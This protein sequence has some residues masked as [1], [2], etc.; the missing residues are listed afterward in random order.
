MKKL[1]KKF[2]NIFG[3]EIQKYN[4]NSGFSNQIMTIIRKAD[5]NIVFDVGAN[6]GQFSLEILK[7]GF[8]G[9]II[10][11]EPLSKAR[12]ELLKNSISFPQWTI[13]DRVALGGNNIFTTNINISKNSVSSSI[14]PMLDDHINAEPESRY[15]DTEKTPVISLDSISQK[16]I[17]ED[18]NCFLKLDVQGFEN[19][20]LDGAIKTLKDIKV[21]LC[22]L[23]LAPLYKGQPNWKDLVLRLERE[24]FVLWA[25]K[26]GFTE[27]KNGR[28]LQIDGVFLKI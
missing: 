10:S 9:N 24:G 5:I 22:E 25:I 26:S 2:L 8:N 18:S 27:Y 17:K 1:I 15:I 20:V 7:K 16:Y 12:K 6:T 13:F 28:T 23:S 11:F 19:E 14:L 4:P 21:I 3:Y